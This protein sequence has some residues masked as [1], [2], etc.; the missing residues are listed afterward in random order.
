MTD[1]LWIISRQSWEKLNLKKIRWWLYTIPVGI[2]LFFGLFAVGIFFG[3][4][5][6]ST[7]PTY[8]PVTK[9]SLSKM[10]CQ[11]LKEMY[12]SSLSYSEVSDV[13][14]IFSEKCL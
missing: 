5:T 8:E 10:N 7:T 12:E 9:D 13:E 1:V 4:Q 2:I 11:K 3:G 14:K 6:N